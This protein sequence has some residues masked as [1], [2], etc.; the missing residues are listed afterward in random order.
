MRITLV[1]LAPVRPSFDVDSLQDITRCLQH[2][3]E[4]IA[5]SQKQ[6]ALM[7]ELTASHSGEVADSEGE[8]SHTVNVLDEPHP[9]L[10]LWRRV[11]RQFWWNESLSK[12][13]VDAGVCAYTRIVAHLLNAPQLHSYV[14]PVMQG[15]YQISTFQTPQDPITG[16]QASVDY[17]IISRRSRDRAGLRY[18]RRGIDDDAHVANFVETETV[19]RVEVRAT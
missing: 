15:Y 18:Q 17:I 1:I 14:L 9:T 2:K 3:Q 16:D 6:H 8:G 5:K 10:P 11:N 19:M 12:A 4:L 13:F 7:D